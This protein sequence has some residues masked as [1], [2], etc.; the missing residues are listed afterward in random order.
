[1]TQ[2]DYNR[3][4]AIALMVIEIII[5]VAMLGLLV[6]WHIR[7]PDSKAVTLGYEK[8]LLEKESNDDWSFMNQKFNNICKDG[9]EVYLWIFANPQKQ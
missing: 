4:E 8:E 7:N 5:I 2:T 6:F 1:M 9:D 3:G